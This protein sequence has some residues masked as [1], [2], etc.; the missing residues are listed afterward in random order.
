MRHAFIGLIGAA[1]VLYA[2]TAMAQTAMDIR[3]P[4]RRQLG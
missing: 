4:A 1:P 2:S 3:G